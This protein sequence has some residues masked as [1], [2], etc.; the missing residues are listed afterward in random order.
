MDFI[1]QRIAEAYERVTRGDPPPPPTMGFQP[2][3][4]ASLAH[5]LKYRIDGYFIISACRNNWVDI[6]LGKIGDRNGTTFLNLPK[7]RQC[8][9]QD[10]HYWNNVKTE[11]LENDLRQL[12]YGF[13]PV[14]GGFRERTPANP[15]GVVV[16]EQSFL[17]PV[18]KVSGSMTVYNTIRNNIINRGIK[19]MQEVVAVCPPN[20]SPYYYVTNPTAAKAPIGTVQGGFPRDYK[21]NDVLQDYFTSLNR[22]H[23]QRSDFDRGTAKRFTFIK[24]GQSS[25]SAGS[26]SSDYS[27]GDSGTD[28][29]DDDSGESNESVGGWKLF[30]SPEPGSVMGGH[31]AYMRGEINGSR[32]PSGKIASY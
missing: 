17:I 4:E 7:N 11:E 8:E 28:E 10:P 29:T 13:V 15:N 19:Y 30:L 21:L 2:L 14:Y 27:A 16:M 32:Y 22:V 6:E 31:V 26:A 25:Q 23:Y 18:Q 1:N 5:V 12:G 9:M 3:T 20:G 24:N